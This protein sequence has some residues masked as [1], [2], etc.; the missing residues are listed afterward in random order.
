MREN[1]HHPL[2]PL[3]RLIRAYYRLL[4]RPDRPEIP[5]PPDPDSFV[6]DMSPP[7][8]AEQAAAQEAAR[9]AIRRLRDPS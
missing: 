9:N 8:A 7:T 1:E 4:G 3:D 6:P 5:L 2:G